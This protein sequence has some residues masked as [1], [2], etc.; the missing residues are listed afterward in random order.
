MSNSKKPKF[1]AKERISMLPAQSST[2]TV[3]WVQTIQ[4]LS[5]CY[6]IASDESPDVGDKRSLERISRILFQLSTNGLNGLSDAADRVWLIEVL[7]T[8][9]LE[10]LAASTNASQDFLH[11][12]RELKNATES[13]KM[14]LVYY[15]TDTAWDHL[16]H[17]FVH[18]KRYLE[19]VEQ[20][21]A[22][23]AA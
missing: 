3:S 10:L 14:T 19:T 5:W 18:A 7:R 21:R 9:N 23:K 12:V 22:E 2:G 13:L 16:K 17:C 11:A 4:A 1:V 8:F 15:A 20:Q 6:I